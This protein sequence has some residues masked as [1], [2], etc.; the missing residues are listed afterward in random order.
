MWP[1]LISIPNCF[2]DNRA[3][4]LKHA[5]PS[6]NALVYRHISSSL[7][8]TTTTWYH[9]VLLGITWFFLVLLLQAAQQGATQATQATSWRSS[10]SPLGQVVQTRPQAHGIKVRKKIHAGRKILR[11]DL[12]PT[13]KKNRTFFI[14]FY[15]DTLLISSSLHQCWKNWE[16]F[17][18]YFERLGDIL[19]KDILPHWHFA[20][21]TFCPRTFCPNF[22]KNSGNFAPIVF[23]YF[24]GIS[25]AYLGHILGISW[26][27]LGH[28]L[29]NNSVM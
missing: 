8:T 1:I 13:E 3:G 20:P 17:D 5:K 11:K 22:R 25:W 24:S 15:F 4:D 16:Y 9:L 28:L 6:K 2:R 27:C 10:L 19:P 21:R 14:R 18:I 23:V 7:Q 26:T 12:F 29:P